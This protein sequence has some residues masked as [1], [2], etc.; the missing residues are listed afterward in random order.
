MSRRRP[1]CG[2]GPPRFGPDR[3]N[4]SSAKS[5]G[6]SSPITCCIT[7]PT[8]P[9]S[10]STKVRAVSV[11]TDDPRWL[12]AWQHGRTGY[13]IVD[14][15]MRELWTTGWMHN[16]VRMIVASLLTKN[17]L[18][19]WLAGARWFWD[20]LVD[21]DLAPTRSAGSG[22]RAAAPTRRRFTA[23]STPCCRPSGSTLS[24]TTC[25]AGC[26][27]LRACPTHGSTGH[28]RR[29]KPC[30]RPP[31]SGSAAATLP[32][33]SISPP[34][35]PRRWQPTPRSG[36]V[37][38]RSG[39]E[40]APPDGPKRWPCRRLAARSP[41]SPPVRCGRAWRRRCTPPHAGPV[42]RRLPA[43]ARGSRQLPG[44]ADRSTRRACG[45]RAVA[46]TAMSRANPWH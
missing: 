38:R 36:R 21:A 45:P 43:A 41:C 8:P 14:A 12:E 6:A 30:C 37:P 16:R 10:H 28:G 29:L 5:A 44:S 2:H 42:R 11:G 19:P 22:L 24:A 27:S 32:R 39:T 33:W 9:D 34:V 18:Q 31:G 1:Q 23:S 7:F 40:S 4:A 20:T 17:L 35:V 25:G 46:S 15:G 13:P 26:L 3:P